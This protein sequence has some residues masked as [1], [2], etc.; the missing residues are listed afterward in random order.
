M[1]FELPWVYFVSLVIFGS[2]FVLNLVLGVLSGYVYIFTFH[3][4]NR[5]VKKKQKNFLNQACVLSLFLLAE[6]FPKSVK[7]PKLAA[8]S[9]SCARSSSWR[10]TLRATWTGSRKPRTSTPRTRRRGTRRASAIVSYQD[11]FDCCL[12]RV[13]QQRESAQD[14][15]IIFF[16]SLSKSLNACEFSPSIHHSTNAC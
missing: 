9:R 10:R 1:G 13:L 2:F 4:S 11:L 3:F 16:F 8:T 15:G 5:K 6:S 14:C 12:L 7:R